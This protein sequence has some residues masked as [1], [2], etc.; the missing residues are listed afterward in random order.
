MCSLVY[1]HFKAMVNGCGYH[2]L[3][4]FCWPIQAY[5]A[6]STMHSQNAHCCSFQKGMHILSTAVSQD[7][8]AADQS[9][10]PTAAST[11]NPMHSSN[12][13]SLAIPCSGKHYHVLTL[14]SFLCEC[15]DA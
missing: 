13:L 4:D 14:I 11:I 1:P 7:D 6:Y 9:S 5:T 10:W 3:L 12:I 2:D 8:G 15:C